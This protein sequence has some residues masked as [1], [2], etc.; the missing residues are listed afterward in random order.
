MTNPRNRNLLIIIAVLLLTNIAVLAYFLGQKKPGKHIPPQA[1]TERAGIA[2]MLQEEVGFNEQQIAEYKVMKDRQ[3]E[4]L[5]PMFD[6]MRKTKDSLFRMLSYE[7]D[8]SDSIVNRLAD[9]IASKQRALDLQTFRYFKQVRELCNAEQQP[10]YDSLILK[11]FR[12]M[13]KRPND[14]EKK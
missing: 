9:A 11:M 6:D 7:G 13:G 10:K 3:R 1:R 2:N 5:R 12:R 14:T 8:G 4:T